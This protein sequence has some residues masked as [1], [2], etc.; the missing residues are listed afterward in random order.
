MEIGFV[1]LGHMGSAMAKNLLEAGHTVTI[2]NRTASRA[3]ALEF[4]GARV[5]ATPAEAARSGIVITMLADDTALASVVLA[6]EGI[7]RA[8]PPQGLHIGMSTISVALSQKLATAHQTAGQC[9][10]SAPV[11]GRP[12]AAAAR[13]IFIVAAGAASDMERCQ[14][15]LAALGQRTFIVGS[16]P[17]T[18]NLVKLIGNFL[19]ASVIE[20][21][22]EAFA[23]ARKSG[24]A[25]DTLLAILSAA[26]FPSPVNQNYGSLIVD[27]RYDP[28]RFAAPLGMKDLRL[29]LEAAGAAGVPLPVA[30]LVYDRFQIAMDRGYAEKDW[31]IIAQVAAEDAGLS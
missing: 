11:F 10:V 3:S 17:Y 7:L 19:I 14:P 27:Q 5:A 8:L 18:A 16:E 29:L 4:L 28:A 31:A 24:L 22:G 25:P 23:L 1:G 30:S 21:Y 26:L 2:W 9:Y 12:E 6:E 20:T 13:K 15:I